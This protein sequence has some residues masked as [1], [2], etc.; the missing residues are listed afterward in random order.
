MKKM[1]ARRAWRIL[2]RMQC[3]RD[4][5]PLER[6]TLSGVELDRCTACAGIWL[7]RGEFEHVRKSPPQKAVLDA[8]RKAAAGA[9]PVQEGLLSCP[10][11]GGRMSRQSFSLTA[12]VMI[13]RCQKCLGYWLDRGELEAA[14]GEPHLLS[15]LQGLAE[16]R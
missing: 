16:L 11:C 4:Q 13:D 9:A 6:F 7:D 10:R 8:I 15:A 2:P 3:P 14:F 1:P 12:Q 5:S